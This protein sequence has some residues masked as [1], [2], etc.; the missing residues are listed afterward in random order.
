MPSKPRAE[1]DIKAKDDSAAGWRSA[2]QRA[3]SNARKLTSTVGAAFG[4]IIG[5]ST[6]TSQISKAIEFGDEIGKLK[7]KFGET[8]GATQELVA[9]ARK[10]DIEIG[11]IATS[12]R[13]MQVGVSQ[14]RTGNKELLETFAALGLKVE[15]ISR[16]DP[17]EQFEVLGDA[18]SRLKDP[19]D[20]ARA[21]VALFGRAGTELLP[22]FEGGAGAIRKA[23]MEVREF[24]QVLSDLDIKK[25]QEA[26]DAIKL[27][28]ATWDSFWRKVAVGTVDYGAMIGGATQRLKEF[29]TQ[30]GVLATGARTLLSNVPFVGQFAF[31]AEAQAQADAAGPPILPA[32]GGRG[33]GRPSPP[34]PGFGGGAAAAA[35]A[36]TPAMR[37]A[38]RSAEQWVIT[39]NE[40]DSSTRKFIEGSMDL[41]DELQNIPEPILKMSE[42]LIQADELQKEFT[43]SMFQN[44][45]DLFMSIGN[46]A[47]DFASSMLNAFKRVLADRATLEFFELLSTLG[48]SLTTKS[49][50]KGF[51]GFIGEGLTSLFGGTKAKGGPLDQG[52]W[53][54]AGER[55]PEPIW[56]GG[57]GA[58]AMGYGGGRGAGSS[59]TIN[60]HIDARNSTPDSLKLLP[61]IMKRNNDALEARIVGRLKS[62][63]YS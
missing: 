37:E 10:F 30:Q 2:I 40:A 60:T 48:G 25:L 54:I 18:I 23:R 15:D 8:A 31:L 24:G 11:S 27:L 4:G 5:I 53:Y 44:F 33:F 46:G 41:S 43:R 49:G 59:V 35:D 6:F 32:G 26:D 56:G 1:Y 51:A 42:S 13:K 34:P 19:A 16:L 9:V 39:I 38:I 45:S 7:V 50:G 17:A 3:D 36:F 22:V 21:A 12:L 28:S 61:E 58:F 57:S 62:G 47:D 14:A 55:G 29:A 20:R 63:R 52:K